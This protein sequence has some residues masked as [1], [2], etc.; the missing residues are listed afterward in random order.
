MSFWQPRR[1]G[2]RAF[3]LAFA[4]A[5]ALLLAASAPARATADAAGEWSGFVGLEVRAFANDG[6]FAGQGENFTGSLVFEPEYFRE[7]NGGRDRAVAKAFLRLDSADDERSHVDLRELYWQRVGDGYELDVGVRTVFWGVAESLHLV[8]IVNQTDLVEDLD[9]EDK[10]GQPMVRLG[11]SR[12]WGYLELFLLP[13]FRERTF[14][15]VDGR[16]RPS[17]IIDTTAGYASSAG[18]GHVDAALRYSHVLGDVD[19]G[20]TYFRGTSR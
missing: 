15:G 17:P 2:L 6:A 8:D 13:G 14:P 9:G 3:G 20:V 16:L 5:P 19:L 12:P 7:W 10:L 1:R 18:D 11:L 4:L